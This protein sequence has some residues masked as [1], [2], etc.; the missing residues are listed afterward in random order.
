MM[1]LFDSCSR[2]D[3]RWQ[4]HAAGSALAALPRLDWR[5]EENVK[6]LLPILSSS[7]P[8]L[9]IK[10]TPLHLFGVRDVS[11]NHTVAL[12]ADHLKPWFE[13]T[14]RTGSKGMRA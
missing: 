10:P 14:V 6:E 13:G 12:P 4:R 8:T 9:K 5:V 2:T 1:R 3:G 7:L 11:C